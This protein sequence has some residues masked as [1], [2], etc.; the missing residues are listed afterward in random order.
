MNR[1]AAILNPPLS[2][3]AFWDGSL[4]LVE[5]FS[6]ARPHLVGPSH[7][8]AIFQVALLKRDL[9]SFSLPSSSPFTPNNVTKV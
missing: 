1:V 3:I 2:L 9:A 4:P 8:L 7:S 6:P 5:T